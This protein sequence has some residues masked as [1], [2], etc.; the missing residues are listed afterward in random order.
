MNDIFISYSR[1]DLEFVTQL[2]QYLT[3]KRI[4]AW[5]DKENIQA[6]DQWR[7]SIVDGIRDCKV[8][9]LVLSP[10]SAASTNIRKE[11]D[12]AERYNKQIVP[13]MWRATEIPVAMEYQ[14][15]GIQWIDFKEM[16]SEENFS[17][18]V[19]ILQQLI[20]GA[21]LSEALS[22]KQVVVESPIPAIPKEEPAPASPR[23]LGGLK[24]KQTIN[25][26]ALGGWVISGVITSLNLDTEDQDFVNGELKWLFNATDNFL[27][28]RR[29]EIDRSQ[30]VIVPIPVDAERQPHA[31]NQLLSTLDVAT[32]TSWE[33]Q[34]ETM[35][36]QIS[37]RLG[38]LNILLNQ[39]VMMGE[40]AKSDI[41][42]QNNIRDE[43]VG[44]IKTLRDMAELMN[45][46]YGIRSSRLQELRSTR[47][48]HA[49]DHA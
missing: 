25:P 29:N 39:E 21:S 28:I 9:L 5:F 47:Q 14:L 23:K 30:P 10:D 4:S 42:L 15:A 43:R 49:E 48:D 46:A 45:Q 2:H 40:A 13:L 19:D 17:E 16:A 26:I 34:L 35:F 31:N 12:L 38:N 8:F 27:K 41:V 22:N 33:Y 44:I 3:K 7:T 24:R 1:R 11:V 32:L 20:D 36:K 37:T 6:V 18:L